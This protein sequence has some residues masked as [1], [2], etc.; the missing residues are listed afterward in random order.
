MSPPNATPKEEKTIVLSSKLAFTLPIVL[1]VVGIVSSNVTMMVGMSGKTDVL[2]TKIVTIS[3]DVAEIRKS[4]ADMSAE[5]TNVRVELAA[6]KA[7]K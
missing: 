6:L 3:E 5:L 7:K 4:M 2:D 1:I